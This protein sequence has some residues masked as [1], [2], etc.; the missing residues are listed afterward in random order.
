MLWVQQFPVQ[1]ATF[2]DSIRLLG[3]RVLGDFFGFL[4]AYRV[5]RALGD[6]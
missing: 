5:L 2:G 4:T 3:L 6:S 1:P